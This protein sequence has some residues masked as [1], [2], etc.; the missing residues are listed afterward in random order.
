MPAFYSVQVRTHTG[1]VREI[2]EDAVSTVLDRR[3]TLSLEDKDQ[4]TRGH[5]FAISDG[6]GGHAAG[7]VASNLVI[8]TLFRSYYA[9]ESPSVRDALTQA[10]AEVN[11]T[12]CSQAQANPAYA[13]M[14]ATLVAAVLLDDELVIA[15]VGDSRAYLFRDGD[16]SQITQDHSWVA[17][18]VKAGVLTKEKAGR[19]PYRN[20]ITR[21]LGPDRDPTP[22]FFQLEAKPGDVLLLCTDGL[23]NLLADEELAQFLRAYPSDQAADILLEQALERGAPDNVTFALI[24][25][26]GATGRQRRK[27]WP[28]LLLIFALILV[29]LFFLRDNF[30]PNSRLRPTPSAVVASD[31]QKNTQA[32]PHPA[33][34][35][36]A[37][38]RPM[39]T[40]IQATAAPLRVAEIELPSNGVGMDTTSLDSRFS[41]DPTSSNGNRGRPQRE[42]YVYYLQ[43]VIETSQADSDAWS[44]TIQHRELGGQTVRYTLIAHGS[45]LDEQA[46]PR[47]GD[48]IAIIAWPASEDQTQGD[49]RLDPLVIVDSGAHPLWMQDGDLE[50]WLAAD[51]RTWVFSVYG[52]GGT[53]GLGV[54]S[55]EAF[56]GL[57]VALWGS[58]ELAEFDATKTLRFKLLDHTPYELHGGAYRQPDN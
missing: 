49:I 15:N 43:G 4:R 34:V 44:I 36:P 40:I 3:E 6:M 2:N 50:T 42:R 57:P 26:L 41:T 24:D 27:T 17:E 13:G 25:I 38:P 11:R 12:V 54:E 19:H 16:I 29:S 46:R 10:I 55:P 48:E 33:T 5:L 58:W 7:E 35:T 52:E 30:G 22:D 14:G 47:A 31:S 53:D 18:Q 37:S 32:S 21:S 56:S 9:S 1:S 23:S 28:W 39:P 20:V 45:W 8:D 51:E